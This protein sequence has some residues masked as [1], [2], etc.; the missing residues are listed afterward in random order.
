[1]QLLEERRQPRQDKRVEH[2]L[3]ATRHDVHDDAVVVGVIKPEVLLADDLTTSG[4]HDL[5]HLLFSVCGQM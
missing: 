3:R 2:D 5:T 4:G 1:M